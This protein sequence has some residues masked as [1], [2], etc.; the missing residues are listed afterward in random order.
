[1]TANTKAEKKITRVITDCD[2]C[3]LAYRPAFLALYPEFADTFVFPTELNAA[4]RQS[5]AI[6]SLDPMPGALEFVDA[7]HEAGIPI[8]IISSLGDEPAA[9]ENRLYNLNSVFG[10]DAFDKIHILP[11]RMSKAEALAALNYDPE[12]TAFVDD[13][14]EHLT[15]SPYIN[16]WHHSPKLMPAH[17]QPTPEI[18]AHIT[19]TVHSMSAAAE[20]I[21]NHGRY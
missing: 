4:F 11:Y 21:L 5:D 17:Q 13:F 18:L 1:M 14:V 19:V 7:L 3:L 8:D 2:E 10:S 20:F 12:T 15:E 6:R 9:R 16:I